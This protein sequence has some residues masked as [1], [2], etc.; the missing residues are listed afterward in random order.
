[1]SEK[2]PFYA[3]LRTGAPT[4]GDGASATRRLLIAKREE[5]GPAAG[6]GFQSWSGVE[7]SNLIRCSLGSHRW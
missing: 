6:T 7:E 3:Y 2:P 4:I 5:T 1:M